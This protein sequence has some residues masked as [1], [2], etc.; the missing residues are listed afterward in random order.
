MF[1][2]HKARRE[3]RRAKKAT[4]QLNQD[5]EHWES[6]QPARDKETQDY[7]DQQVLD[8]TQKAKQDRM[9]G[10]QQGREYSDDVLSRNYEGLTPQQKAEMQTQAHKQVKR[11]MQ[12]SQRKMLGQQG[13]HGIVGK[14][15]VAYAQQRDLEK[16]AA[17]VEG[18]RMYDI[19]KIDADLAL[20]KMAAAFGI[21]QGEAAMNQL[22]KQMALDELQLLEEKKKQ[23]YYE[24]KSDQN[25]SRV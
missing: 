9:E 7:Q 18:E 17:D 4:A 10:R 6:T 20:K 23:K 19:N 1:G 11:S 16:R 5:K 3:A 13:Q 8:K 22:D 2:Y 12:S 21:E 15:G 25:F 14:G 24:N